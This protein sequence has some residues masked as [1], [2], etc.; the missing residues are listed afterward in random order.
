MDKK[1]LISPTGT[2]LTDEHMQI[3]ESMSMKYEENE[4]MALRNYVLAPVLEVKHYTDKL[5]SFRTK[6]SKKIKFESGGC[7]TMGLIIRGKLVFRNYYICSPTWANTLEFYSMVVPNGL[8]TP[9]LRMITTRSLVIIK[10]KIKKG[11]VIKALSPGK[12]LFLLCTD[13]GIAVVSNI[14]SEPGTYAKFD[15]VI[16]VMVCKYVEELQYFDDKLKQLTTAPQIKSYAKNKLRFYRSVT[17]EPYPYSGDLTW[18]IKSGTLIADLMTY[19]FDKM[20]RFMVCGSQ[21]TTLDGTNL[22][23]AL[24]YNEGTVNNPQDFVYERTFVS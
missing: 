17:H 16:V 5:F 12:R 20:D 11:L 9:F 2:L 6:R 23:K 22:L 21:Q 8:F 24:G 3:I 10:K 19:N 15:E 18:L 13:I 4:I 7:V 1:M 14:I